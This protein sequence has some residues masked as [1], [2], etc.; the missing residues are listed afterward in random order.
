[1]K[2]GF[3]E[4]GHFFWRVR[5]RGSVPIALCF[6]CQRTGLRASVFTGRQ[7]H[8]IPVMAVGRAGNMD[9]R[10]GRLVAGS[11][12]FI[13]RPAN[14]QPSVVAE[15]ATYSVRFAPSGFAHIFLMSPDGGVPRQLTTGSNNDIVPSWSPNGKWLY[16]GSNRTGSWQMPPILRISIHTNING[17]GR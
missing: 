2:S 6:C 8:R 16:F 12:D 3:R 4:T 14:R 15:R 17:A 13:W 7:T 5:S 9:L 10:G 1:M 11:V